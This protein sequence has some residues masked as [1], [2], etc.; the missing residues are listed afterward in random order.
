MYNLD[1]HT[2]L[3]HYLP[4]RLVFRQ[5]SDCFAPSNIALSK[6]WGKRH[7]GLNL[8][9]NS[10]L[11]ISLGDWGSRTKISLSAD[12]DDHIYFNGEKLS[13]DI[14][15]ATKITNFLNLFRRDQK[16]PLL[17]ETFNS[18]PTAAGLA[19]SASG[20]AALVMAIDTAFGLDLPKSTLSMF[21]R[22][23]SGSASRS[24]W[25]GFVQW[26]RG[27]KDDGTD[28]IA[29]PLNMEWD[30]FRI[31][32]LPVDMGPKSHSSR[33]G[34]N[35]TTVT[36]PLYQSWPEQ[37]EA[38]CRTIRQ[39]VLDKDFEKLGETAEANALA[40]HATM[41]A[42]R[43]ALIYLQPQSWQILNHV[44]KARQDGHMIF[45]TIDAGPNIKLIFL[46]PEEEFVK[47]AFPEAQIILPFNL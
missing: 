17:I 4:E 3:N 39:A 27:K 30:D 46:S 34:M 16:I 7:K 5:K 15:F 29:H 28:S 36:S 24:L 10:S 37:A 42:A 33:N 38:D 20:F 31:A 2:I 35:H 41:L 23:G 32:I 43:P 47:K 12:T 13:A 14:P 11:S 22:M 45:A 8:P 18:I 44:H 1:T 26:D 25:H 6:Y 9:L 19:S 21:A 40:M